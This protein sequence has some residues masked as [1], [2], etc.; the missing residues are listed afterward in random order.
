MTAEP[1]DPLEIL[2]N[3][4]EYPQLWKPEPGDQIEGKIRRMTEVM[5][6]KAGETPV[7]VVQT[8]PDEVL[9][10]FCS[11]TVLKNELARL[12]PEVGE[13]ILIRFLGKPTGRD[14][15]KYVVRIK[16]RPDGGGVNWAK[17]RTEGE[18]PY[19]A[20]MGPQRRQDKEPQPRMAMQSARPQPQPTPD[21]DD[22]FYDQ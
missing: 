22:P 9:S 5:L 8:S 17:Y 1:K 11:A 13:T 7:L 10:V 20:G 4:G 14:Y 18:Q 12:E 15:Y 19:S 21:E 3:A 6:E 16:D 2:D